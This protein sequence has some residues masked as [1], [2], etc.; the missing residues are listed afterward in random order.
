MCTNRYYLIDKAHWVRKDD[1]E[2]KSALATSL[3]DGE[4][5]SRYFSGLLRRLQEV[6]EATSHRKETQEK[7]NTKKQEAPLSK[8]EQ[9]KISRRKMEIREMIASW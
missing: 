2:V 4:V 5:A 1:E 7:G 8:E 9:Q 6:L 3:E